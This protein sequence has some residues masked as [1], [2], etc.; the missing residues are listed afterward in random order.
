MEYSLLYDKS[1]LLLPNSNTFSFPVSVALL[2]TWNFKIILSDDTSYTPYTW[3]TTIDNNN[4]ISIVLYGWYSDKWVEND[5][6]IEI[7]SKNDA[8]KLAIKIRV[9][10]NQYQP[11]KHIM[12]SIWKKA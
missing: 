5:A 12:V 1:V 4:N 11:Q 2:G 6:P 7:A 3:N 10:M 8:I 9:E